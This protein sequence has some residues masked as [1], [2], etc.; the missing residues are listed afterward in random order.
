VREIHR[1]ISRD[2]PS[3]ALRVVQGIYEKAHLPLTFP[4]VGQL[5]EPEKYP[6]VR[7]LLYRRYR[8]A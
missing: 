5:Y 7:L 4:D 3:A 6:G 2:S 1:Y 8:I